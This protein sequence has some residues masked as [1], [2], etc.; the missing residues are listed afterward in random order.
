MKNI[1]R[2]ILTTVAAIVSCV[3]AADASGAMGPSRPTDIAIEA[4]RPV[5]GGFWGGEYKK[6]VCKWIPHCMAQME[7][8]GA[9]EELLNLVATGEVLAGKNPSVEFKGC[10]W[11]DAYPYNIIEAA[12]LALELDPGDDAELKAGQDFL[13][14]KIEEW[15]PVILAA[16][17]PSGYIHS[18]HALNGNKHFTNE[19]DHEFYVMGYFIEMGI[20]HRR[21][22]GDTRLFDAAVKCA[23]HLCD[24]FGPAPKRTWMNGHPGLEMALQRLSVATGDPKYSAL[25][26]HFVLTQSSQEAHR[27]TYSQSDKPA[28]ELREAAGHAVRANYFYTAMADVPECEEAV[29]AIWEDIVDRKMYLTGGT[30]SEHKREAYGR[31]YSLPQDAYAESCAGC[32]LAFLARKMSDTDRERAEAVYERVIYNNILGAISRDGT[33][34]YYQNPLASDVARY[35]W[36]FCPCCVGNIPRTLL[37]LKDNL[38]RAEGDTLYIDQYMDIANVKVGDWLVTMKTD[39]P[40]SD[41]VS[42]SFAGDARPAKIVARFPNR[43]ESR[44]YAATPEVWHGYRETGDEFELPMPLQKVV[45]DERVESCRGLSAYQ[46]GPIVYSWEGEKPERR[47]PNYD[48]LND[49]GYSSVWVK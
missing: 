2:R 16:Q 25:A 23:D 37:A 42:L 12:S 7:K 15:I 9:G 31:A 38:F 18:Y 43:A 21:A 45:A 5:I 11:S 28:A 34:F 22:T 39:Y 6:L 4:A 32:G 36:H 26:R 35:A 49:G 29:R 40:A 3:A 46:Q 33:K 17:E 30:G 19:G 20:A 13:R 14:T 10:K 47:V 44:L 41:K 27:S 24:I 48:R 8:G 1:V